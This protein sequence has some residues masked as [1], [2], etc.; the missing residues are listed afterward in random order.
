MHAPSL[1]RLPDVS[2]SPTS[3][4]TCGSGFQSRSVT[5]MGSTSSCDWDIGF[6]GVRFAV[7]E[8]PVL[9]VARLDCDVTLRQSESS[10]Q[11]DSTTASAACPEVRERPDFVR[12]ISYIALPAAC[13]RFRLCSVHAAARVVWSC[14]ASYVAFVPGCALVVEYNSTRILLVARC[15]LPAAHEM[16]QCRVSPVASRMCSR[17][18]ACRLLPVARCRLHAARCPLSAAGP[19][20][21]LLSLALLHVCCPVHAVCCRFRAVYTKQGFL[22]HAARCPLPGACCPLRCMT[23]LLAACFM[24][25]GACCTLHAARCLLRVACRPLHG[26]C[27]P[28]FSVARCVSSV[29]FS[30][31]RVACGVV[32]V[33]KFPVVPCTFSLASSAALRFVGS[34]LLHVGSCPFSCGPPQCP[35]SRGVWCLS[36]GPHRIA[37]GTCPALRVVR[38]MLHD[39]RSQSH[40]ASCVLPVPSCM[41]SV[42]CCKTRVLCCFLSLVHA[43]P[44]LACRLPHAVC[45]NV[46]CRVTQRRRIRSASR[47]RIAIERLSGRQDP[48]QTEVDVRAC[49]RACVWVAS[50]TVCRCG[51]LCVRREYLCQGNRIQVRPLPHVFDHKKRGHLPRHQR[52]RPRRVH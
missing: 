49:V 44:I 9:R 18:P 30:L 23:L 51:L 50:V 32:S 6:R 40:V 36:P 20:V 47:R 28:P 43:D 35:M 46:A 52:L 11:S 31:L 7:P 37:S 29:A 16:R 2:V 48:L 33:A 24:K 12:L 8:C 26:A 4:V 10:I 17:P 34:C 19:H 25:S 42:G 41:P 3:S 22:L 13:C 39:A 21:A 14:V 45:C 1:R 27:C 15:P 5:C 38:C